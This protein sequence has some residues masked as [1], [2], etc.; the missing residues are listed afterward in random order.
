[1]GL[2]GYGDAK[3][4]NR[5]F[6]Y[7]MKGAIM[8]RQSGTKK[9][10]E[11]FDTL[12]VRIR[13]RFLKY[14]RKAFHMLPKMDRPRILDIGCGSGIPTLELA[15]LSRSEVIG[16]DINQPALDKF[17]RKIKEAGLTDRV[18]AINCSMFDMD[19]ADESFD[20]IWS[21][22]SIYAI[23]FE[24]GLWEWKRFLKAGGSMVVHD[25][26]GNVREKLEQISNCGYEL[27]GHFML[28]EETWQTE[29]FTPLEKLVNEYR[30]KYSDASQRFKEFQKAREELDMF[31]ENPERNSSVYFVMIRR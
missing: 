2:S 24:K 26:Q 7:G 9:N 16:I 22:G 12:Y 13:K 14:T 28:S 29:Y 30:N 11:H 4:V 19:F 1:V 3:E 25:E 5:A 21:E 17:V 10:G 27:I 15:R 31:K 6:Q 18:Q 20:V 23:G 8:R